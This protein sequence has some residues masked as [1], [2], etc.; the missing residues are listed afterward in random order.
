MFDILGTID[1]GPK[2]AHSILVNREEERKLIDGGYVHQTQYYL[3][4]DVPLFTSISPE[5]QF[6]QKIKRCVNNTV[7]LA[8]SRKFN[9]YEWSGFAKELKSLLK[10]EENDPRLR[11]LV[12][13]CEGADSSDDEKLIDHAVRSIIEWK[14]LDSCKGGLRF[15]GYPG[16]SASWF[17]TVS[18]SAGRDETEVWLETVHSYMEGYAVEH[19]LIT[20]QLF[21]LVHDPEIEALFH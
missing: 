6:Q 8:N 11:Q 21:H 15:L 2:T 9:F 17:K 13:L 12:S 1:R 7:Y 4:R 14:E 18:R 20:P 3:V 19:H 10:E 16:F 5:Q